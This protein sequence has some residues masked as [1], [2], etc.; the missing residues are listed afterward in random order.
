MIQYWSIFSGIL[1]KSGQ[2]LVS[3]LGKSGQYSGQYT[4]FFFYRPQLSSLLMKQSLCGLNIACCCVKVIMITWCLLGHPQFVMVGRGETNIYDFFHTKNYTKS[5]LQR[6]MLKYI[7]KYQIK[8]SFYPV[9]LFWGRHNIFGS[10][11][12]KEILKFSEAGERNR[13]VWEAGEEGRG[14]KFFWIRQGGSQNS[15][16]KI[17]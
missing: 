6:L 4:D 1:G 10:K 9:Q 2:Y 14:I 8:H 17:I 3:I 15:D 7:D 16:A 5:I 13:K 12:G 11:G